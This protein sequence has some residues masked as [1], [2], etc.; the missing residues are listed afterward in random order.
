MQKGSTNYWLHSKPKS[1]IER[2][3]VNLEPGIDCRQD[4]WKPDT[5][6]RWHHFTGMQLSSRTNTENNFLII[7]CTKASHVLVSGSPGI[8]LFNK[9]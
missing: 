3:G 8:L 5:K 2:G 7:V 4:I 6:N 1:L 9:Q